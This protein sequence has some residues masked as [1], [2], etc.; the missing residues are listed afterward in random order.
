MSADEPPPHW[1]DLRAAEGV[2]E[3]EARRRRQND[4]TNTQK[5]SARQGAKKR[6]ERMTKAAEAVE[7]GEATERQKTHVE[8]G[9]Q[10]VYA[11]KGRERE[12]ERGK[13]AGILD[14]QHSNKQRQM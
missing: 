4:M 14:N 3:Q 8:R 9:G 5:K 10:T 12:R 2:D 13:A 1:F 11:T 6:A 7:K